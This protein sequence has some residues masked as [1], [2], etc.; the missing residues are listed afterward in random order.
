MGGPS[1]RQN[2]TDRNG[3]CQGP[4]EGKWGVFHGA[5]V[6]ALQNENV[7]EVDGGHGGTALGTDLMPLS[8][9]ALGTDLHGGTALG[10]DLMPLSGTALGTDAAE[11]HTYAF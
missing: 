6:S 8:G 10:T 3:V 5:R 11:R 9:T 1:S 2:H 4:G 7:L